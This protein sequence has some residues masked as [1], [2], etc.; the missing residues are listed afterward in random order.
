MTF[1]L[2]PL[3]IL[4]IILVS[5][6][7]AP[8]LAIATNVCKVNNIHVI[9]GNKVQVTQYYAGAAPF[10][11]LE[12]IVFL[13]KPGSNDVITPYSNDGTRDNI[14]TQTLADNDPEKAN[15]YDGSITYTFN[16]PSGANAADYNVYATDPNDGTITCSNS[17]TVGKIVPADG[18]TPAAPIVAPAADP[19][20]NQLDYDVTTYNLKNPQATITA[21]TASK[22]QL[23]TYNRCQAKNKCSARVND[24]QYTT[25]TYGKKGGDAGYVFLPGFNN[26]C[27]NLLEFSQTAIN[28]ALFFATLIA[29]F[30]FAKGAF[31]ILV[32]RGN[33]A[34]VADAR[35]TLTNATIGLILLASA[36]LIIKFL[37]GAFEGVDGGI[38]LLGPWLG[39]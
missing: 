31:G 14:N 10:G 28:Y 5:V 1:K 17:T 36:F 7:I 21:G 18:S 20:Q 30:M 32:S 8:P 29:G 2:W 27:N 24:A 11:T 12:S 34:S 6:V 9:D 4:P 25:S 19:C 22:A 35:E 33:P 37:N 16:L 15:G 26:A 38:N 23:I 13:R 3:L 39:K